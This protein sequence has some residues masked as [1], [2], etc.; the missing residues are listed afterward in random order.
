[1]E[2]LTLAR[3]I[4]ETSLMFFEFCR[5]S[6][7]LMAVASYLLAIRMKHVGDWVSIVFIRKLFN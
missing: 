3:Y 4:L 5:V 7:S 2:T 1:M 6:E